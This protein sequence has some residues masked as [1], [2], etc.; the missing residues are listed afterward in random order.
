ME[1]EKYIREE[2]IITNYIEDE[3][4]P[5]VETL[6]LEEFQQIASDVQYDF[7]TGRTYIQKYNTGIDEELNHWEDIFLKGVNLGVAL[8]GKFPAE[9]SM[10]FEQYLDWFKMI[11]E[12]NSNVIRLYTILPPDFYKAIAYYN[13]HNQ[14]MPLYIM[15]GIWAKIPDDDDYFNQDYTRE[16]QKELIDA[17]DVIHGNAVLKEM[18]GKAHGIYPTDVSKYVIGFLL[19]R[20]WEPSCVSHTIQSYDVNSYDGDFISI[21]NGNPMEVWLAKMLDFTAMYETQEYRW[22]HPLSFVNW[23]PLDPMYHNSE[24]IENEKVR[25]YD[26]DMISIDFRKFN[27]TELF[28][29][30]IYAAYHV[31]P[32]YPDFIYLQD[33]YVNAINHHGIKDNFFG[34]LEDLKQH[35]EG[36]PL[37]ISEYGLPT[38]RGISHFTPSGFNQGGHSEAKQAELS[39]TLTEDIYETN[40]AGAIYF[41]WAD[42]WFKHNWLVLDFEVPFENRKLWHNMENPEQNFG[43]LALENKKKIIDASLNDWEGDEENIEMKVW[44]DAD[45]TYFYLAG[46]F[47]DLDLKKHNLYIAIDTYSEDKGDHSLPFTDKIFDNGFEF[48]CE[49]KS[50][51]TAKILVDEPYSVFTDIYNDD[52]P[53]YASV[54]NKNGKFVDELML[55]NRGREGLIGKKTDSILNNRSPLIYGNTSYPEFSNADWNWSYMNKNFELRLDWHLINISD[56]STRFVLDDSPETKSIEA[57][58]TDGFNIYFFITDKNDSVILQYPEDYPFYFS[59]DGWTQPDFTERLKPVYD[60]LKTYFKNLKSKKEKDFYAGVQDETFIITPFFNDK[61]AAVSITFENAGYSQYEYALPVL[62]KYNLNA[63]FSLIPNVLEDL[64]NIINV[65]EGALIKRMGFIQIRE[66]YNSGNEIVLQL[67]AVNSQDVN[68]VLPLLSDFNISTIHSQEN[69][70]DL[71]EQILFVRKSNTD[72]ELISFH[73]NIPFSVVNTNMSQ[74]VLDSTLKANKGNWSIFVYHHINRDTALDKK[75]TNDQAEKYFIHE[76]KF[77]RQ[78]RLIRNSD[79]WIAPESIVYKYLKEKQASEIE[80]KRYENLIFLKIKNKLNPYIFNHPLTVRYYSTAKIIEVS[81]SAN[82]GIYENRTGSILLNV[83]PEKEVKLEIVKR[84]K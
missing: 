40:C 8:P 6:N 68:D 56:P 63:D 21:A 4:K 71:P 43:I 10:S 32:Y 64:P 14:N 22:Q 25:E 16:F 73:E 51:D 75:F 35:T 53:V 67:N 54:N 61:K 58:Q 15:Q 28:P 57:S 42:E 83:F 23:L 37:V 80:V 77:K 47:P 12:M 13:L 33:K 62:N 9:F 78:I 41:E 74:M 39:L 29:A 19:G 38:S 65:D 44:A 66:I 27:A 79:Y 50:K 70:K 60:T 2:R 7:K 3:T 18:P 34:Y 82:D 11:G 46:K 45:P 72:N 55:V 52:I 5:L 26:N 49:F 20:E 30:G 1:Y 36:M 76:E 81:G 59:W 31:Y 48:L 69:V 84:T 24:F 17:I